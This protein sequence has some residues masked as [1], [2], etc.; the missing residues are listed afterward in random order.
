[1]K[2]QKILDAIYS[3]GGPLMQVINQIRCNQL[4]CS[5]RTEHYATYR[6][7]G[8]DI[9]LSTSFISWVFALD[10]E[11]LAFEP[12][13]EETSHGH[14]SRNLKKET[15]IKSELQRLIKKSR[16]ILEPILSLMF[17]HDRK[18]DRKVKLQDFLSTCMLYLDL[19]HT[20][21]WIKFV[22]YQTNYIFC[23][24]LDQELPEPIE[25]IHRSGYLL[26]GRPQKWLAN[27]ARRIRGVTT[28]SQRYK[29]VLGFLFSLIN[30]VKRAMPK[31]SEDFI[32]EAL[33]KH[34]NTLSKESPPL[35]DDFLSFIDEYT[36]QLIPKISWNQVNKEPVTISHRACFERNYKD[37]GCLGEYISEFYGI[38]I[39]D[40][41]E[42][43][44]LITSIPECVGFIEDTRRGKVE[45][46]YGYSLYGEYDHAL[47]HLLN[48][49]NDNLR[50]R[51][52][53]EGQVEHTDEE[54]SP[55]VR[56]ESVPLCEPLKVRVI[57]KS[58]YK[59]NSLLR[60][61]QKRMWSSLRQHRPFR[62]IG[63]KVTP[64]L[65]TILEQQHEGSIW[66]SGDY[67]QATDNLSSAVT[68]RII[69]NISA[70]P[71]VQTALTQAL[72]NN[73]V[74]Y[75]EDSCIEEF[76][77]KRGQLMGCLFS[78]PILCIANYLVYAY[79]Y[80]EFYG[81]SKGEFTNLPVLVNGDD[82]LF[83]DKKSFLESGG[84]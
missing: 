37:G 47:S 40:P 53:L 83:K 18:Y 80:R 46:V 26:T 16:Q 8:V 74:Y 2:F 54:F 62:L 38:E 30:G 44:C 61:L 7:H 29:D 32:H 77:M 75:P 45:S 78:F 11:E 70:D 48:R 10:G 24:T 20:D 34:K 69:D 71:M 66:N 36:N 49:S 42:R 5:L 31:V 79:T 22:K 21:H 56:T 63:E 51:V 33:I 27:I 73:M 1:M 39:T 43:F 52:N 82:I 28:E 6:I 23:Q 57:T 12:I 15:T 84:R 76:E 14:S 64:E 17:L 67:S 13:C 50:S 60:S 3:T 19:A 25:T 68:K 41:Y 55:L 81:L 59:I 65:L 35:D 58:E 72:L 9:M 4:M